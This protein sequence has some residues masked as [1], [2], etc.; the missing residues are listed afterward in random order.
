MKKKKVEKPKERRKEK[1]LTHKEIRKRF[2]KCGPDID[3]I[4]RN[5]RNVIVNSGLFPG[6]AEDILAKK[7]ERLPKRVY[8]NTI[9]R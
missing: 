7:R 5:T 3:A 9:S 2:C 6:L 4:M 1:R 8:R